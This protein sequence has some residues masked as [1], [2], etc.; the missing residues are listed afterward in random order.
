MALVDGYFQIVL[1]SPSQGLFL[2]GLEERVPHLQVLRLL[3]TGTTAATCR[4]VFPG[5]SARFGPGLLRS[6]PA[7][8]GPTDILASITLWGRCRSHV[9]LG[10]G[11]DPFSLDITVLA[12]VMS[13]FDT[14][15][16]IAI[17]V[18]SLDIAAVRLKCVMTRARKVSSPCF[19][20]TPSRNGFLSL[21][22]QAIQPSSLNPSWSYIL[23]ITNWSRGVHCTPA[24]FFGYHFRI[25]ETFNFRGMIV[26][27]KY[28]Y[29]HTLIVFF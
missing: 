3:A 9:L 2:E 28:S 17:V 12:V 24:L 27:S 11:C 1:P 16:V 23:I 8:S 15:S 26:Q 20:A 4:V 10:Q 13:A 7:N 22:T 25:L 14:H 6:F 21:Y 5:S 29:N 18:S 19:W